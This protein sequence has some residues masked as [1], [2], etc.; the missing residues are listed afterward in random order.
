MAEPYGDASRDELRRRGGER[1]A[2]AYGER[3]DLLYDAFSGLDEGLAELGD[4]YVFG[5]IWGRGGLAYEE[6]ML[7]AIAALA[8]GKNPNELR[9]Y[10][11]GALENG[12]EPQKIHEVLVMLSVYGGFP[13]AVQGLLV[14]RD[15][16]RSARQQGTEIDLPI[17]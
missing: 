4:E 17:Q 9:N 7:V 15:V 11:N 16:V 2:L 6:R 5:Q 1:R 8:M 13:V 14:W 3:S 10:L 12:I